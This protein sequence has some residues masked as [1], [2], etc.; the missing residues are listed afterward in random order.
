VKLGKD[1]D[2]IKRVFIEAYP[3]PTQDVVNI[4]INKD[5]KKASVDVYNLIGQHLQSKDVKYRSTPISLGNYPSGVYILKIN[6][7]NQ[8]ESIKIIKK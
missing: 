7:D 1:T 4:L 2:D 3:N 8:T 6:H 5:F